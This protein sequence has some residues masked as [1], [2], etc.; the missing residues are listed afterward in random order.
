M[1]II[2]L[3]IGLCFTLCMS[4]FSQDEVFLYANLFNDSILFPELKRNDPVS[5]YSEM[6]AEKNLVKD[7]SENV[8]EEIKEGV[9]Q[10][11]KS[12]ENQLQTFYMKLRDLSKYK[13]TDE[14][15]KTY[16]TEN[17]E[18][19]TVKETREFW[20][21]FISAW[22][23]PDKMNWERARRHKVEAETLLYLKNKPLE[24]LET[25]FNEQSFYGNKCKKI[26]PAPKGKYSEQIS[27]IV[28]SLKENQ[29]T[30]FIKTAKG[31]LKIKL[32]KIN[33]SYV[34]PLEEV[35]PVIRKT[36]QYYEDQKRM[37]QLKQRIFEK[38]RIQY[39]WDQWNRDKTPEQKLEELQS[40]SKNLSVSEDAPTT[41][42]Q[43]MNFEQTVLDLA[44]LKEFEDLPTREKQDYEQLKRFFKTRHLSLK[45][46]DA[47]AL[48]RSDR[49]Y[50]REELEEFYNQHP[51]HFYQKGIIE[52]RMATFKKGIES[53]IKAIARSFNTP[54]KVANNFYSRLKDGEDFAELAK[55]L[56]Q[57]DNAKNGGY[58]GIIDEE[59]SKM[60]AIFDINTFQLKEGEYTKPLV[61]RGRRDYIIIK[62]D[63]VI[64]EHKLLPLDEVLDKAN[65]VIRRYKK[66]DIAMELAY[67]Y[68]EKAR[69]QVPEEVK[70]RPELVVHNI[71]FQ[72]M[73]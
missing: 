13:I 31:F 2:I 23:G 41:Y 3:L 64:R 32:V 9:D 22:G 24:S 60:G 45:A 56:S 14:Q 42:V 18:K 20:Y 26:G 63:K 8:P 39:D 40:L 61:R 70:N 47:E 30:R 53:K 4:V 62:A 68:L 73:Q 69:S 46:L 1:G 37:D 67:E 44:L 17:L 19:F 29:E 38:Y 51:G 36:V 55:T 5:A 66:N 28:F 6:N 72:W 21:L 58:L 71:N 15:L 43:R 52:A 65:Q 7:F 16:Y 27:E 49:E 10:F 11:V 35:E 59:K 33:P 34:K 48:K 50:T 54:K 25:K 12:R 57:D